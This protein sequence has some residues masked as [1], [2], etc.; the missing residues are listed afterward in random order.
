MDTS[1]PKLEFSSILV[2]V[3]NGH[4]HRESDKKETV[5]LKKKKVD[6]DMHSESV[7]SEKILLSITFK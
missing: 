7:F 3:C 4:G 1:S 2:R 6:R 5:A